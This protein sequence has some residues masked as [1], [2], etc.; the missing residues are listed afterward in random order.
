MSKRQGEGGGGEG[1]RSEGGDME[2]MEEVREGVAGGPG[3]GI[4]D[5]WMSSH[6]M[7]PLAMELLSSGGVS[8]CTYVHV[9]VHVESTILTTCVA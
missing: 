6:E 2:E 3:L 7:T 5:K 4:R 8:V 9:R 1:E